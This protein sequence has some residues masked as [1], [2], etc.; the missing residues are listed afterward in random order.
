MARIKT[1][2]RIEQQIPIIPTD[3]TAGRRMPSII[4]LKA[5]TYSADGI[6]SSSEPFIPAIQ[7]YFPIFFLYHT[8]TKVLRGK[9]QK[10]GIFRTLS[11]GLESP[12]LFLYFW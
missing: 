6:K 9:G 11:G 5:I 12:K 3:P 1:E 10:I 4:H 8:V 7:L 2:M